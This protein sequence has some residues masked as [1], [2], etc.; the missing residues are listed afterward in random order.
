[1]RS[2]LEPAIWTLVVLAVLAALAALVDAQFAPPP[3]VQRDSSLSIGG[4]LSALFPRHPSSNMPP[5][6]PPPPQ[7]PFREC[8]RHLPKRSS[9]P[10]LAAPYVDGPFDDYYDG[11]GGGV[12]LASPAHRFMSETS[13]G[14]RAATS[15]MFAGRVA[16][17]FGGGGGGFNAPGFGDSFGHASLLTRQ[18]ACFVIPMALE[19]LRFAIENAIFFHFT[20]VWAESKLWVSNLLSRLV[21]SKANILTAFVRSLVCERMAK[22]RIQNLLFF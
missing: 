18:A 21:F 22:I 14:R 13:G 20:I 11:G 2:S 12:A 3:H 15:R 1:M 17:P 19:A 9:A 16:A 5:P 10:I 8:R 4:I 7:M 6:P